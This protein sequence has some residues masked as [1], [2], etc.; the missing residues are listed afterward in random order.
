[1]T[2][3][4]PRNGSLTVSLTLVPGIGDGHGIQIGE[5]RLAGWRTSLDGGW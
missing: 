2:E 4:S 1:M 3:Q 5:V